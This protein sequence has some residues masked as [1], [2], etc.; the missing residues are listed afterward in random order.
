MRPKP[1]NCMLCNFVLIEAPA[2][3]VEY[4]KFILGHDVCLRLKR[5]PT[6]DICKSSF[7][8]GRYSRIEVAFRVASNIDGSLV[9][10]YTSPVH[11]DIGVGAHVE[12]VLLI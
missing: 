11:V 6:P 1:G 8:V 4:S 2:I 5:D 3:E 10:E 9:V 12:E 7:Q